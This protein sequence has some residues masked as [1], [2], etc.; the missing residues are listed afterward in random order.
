MYYYAEDVFPN[1]S[2]GYRILETPRWL[3]RLFEPAPMPYV[4]VA[5]RPGNYNWG[6]QDL[7]RDR[8]FRDAQ[9]NQQEENVGN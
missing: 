8:A 2:Y 9:N 1:L 5:D 7:E 3:K 6:A 4:E